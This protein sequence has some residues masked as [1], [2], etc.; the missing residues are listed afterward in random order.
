MMHYIGQKSTIINETVQSIN[1]NVIKKI[2]E[3]QIIK[4]VET[5]LQDLL[6]HQSA[7]FSL[8]IMKQ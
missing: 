8:I 4:K 1:E 6:N 3:T 5:K 2:Q 7:N